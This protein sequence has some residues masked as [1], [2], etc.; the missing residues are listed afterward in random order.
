MPKRDHSSSTCCFFS[1]NGTLMVFVMLKPQ[2]IFNICDAKP[3]TLQFSLN[4]KSASAKS[5]SYSK[6]SVIRGIN[7][8]RLPLTLQ[9]DED[10]LLHR[11]RGKSTLTKNRPVFDPRRRV[12]RGFVRYSLYRNF[13]IADL[14]LVVV[15]LRPI[16]C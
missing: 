14:G 13:V 3:Q 8:T 2:T 15:K 10:P 9:D 5:I 11:P 7:P 12:A 4:P 1:F 6:A 16:Y